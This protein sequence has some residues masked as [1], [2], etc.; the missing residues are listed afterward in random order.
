MPVRPLVALVRR[1]HERACNLPQ[2][3][4]RGMALQVLDAGLQI[5]DALERG[6]RQSVPLG[7]PPL[8]FSDAKRQRKGP[9]LHYMRA[10]VVNLYLIT[11]WKGVWMPLHRGF[12]V[13]LVSLTRQEPAGVPGLGLGVFTFSSSIGCVSPR[14]KCRSIGVTAPD[15]PT[16]YS[17]AASH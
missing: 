3:D 17:V 6:L 10:H 1:G 2:G 16:E 13:R 7:H 15:M 11:E 8:Q 12:D 9:I 4:M 5:L 14:S